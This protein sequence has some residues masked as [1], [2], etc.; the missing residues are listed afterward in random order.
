VVNDQVIS[1]AS[2]G[3][4]ATWVLLGPSANT[5][6]VSARDEAGSETME[7]R[8]ATYTEAVLADFAA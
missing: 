6:T 2:D 4:F 5:V 8:T 3:S 1:I 7:T